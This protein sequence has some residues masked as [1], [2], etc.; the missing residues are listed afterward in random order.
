MDQQK[1]SPEPDS[2]QPLDLVIH[3]KKKENEVV[4]ESKPS[5]FAIRYVKLGN[6]R[7]FLSLRFYAKSKMVNF[8]S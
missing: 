4:L 8:E 5:N 7:I 6:Y 3:S 2:E 1:S